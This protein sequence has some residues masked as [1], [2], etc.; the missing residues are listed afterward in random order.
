MTRRTESLQTSRRSDAS[1]LAKTKPGSGEEHLRRPDLE[2]LGGKAELD[3]AITRNLGRL[4]LESRGSRRENAGRIPRPN[5]PRFLS[6]N[7]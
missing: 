3:S 7:P 1:V 6:V 2:G 5:A 4:T